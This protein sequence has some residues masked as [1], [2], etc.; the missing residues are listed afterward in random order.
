MMCKRVSYPNKNLNCATL[1][2]PLNVCYAHACA[3]TLHVCTCGLGVDR[4]SYRERER[5]I[6]RWNRAIYSCTS[7]PTL[8]PLL[9]GIKTPLR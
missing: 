6:L 5:T 2:Q 3:V 4:N 8:S 7:L 9:N 1:A